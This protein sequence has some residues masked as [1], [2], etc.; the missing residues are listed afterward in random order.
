M[1]DSTTG[2]TRTVAWW[3]VKKSKKKLFNNL[4]LETLLALLNLFEMS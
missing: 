2:D 3:Y 4:N 1:V